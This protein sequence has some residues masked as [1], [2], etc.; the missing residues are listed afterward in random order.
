MIKE[1]LSFN[2]AFYASNLWVKKKL[3]Q[4][5]TKLQGLIT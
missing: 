3:N 2:F 5:K 1:V 4:E